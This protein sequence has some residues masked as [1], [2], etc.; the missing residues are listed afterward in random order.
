MAEVDLHLHTTFSDGNLSPTKLVRLC[1]SRGLKAIAITDHDS[2]EGLPEALAVAEELPGVT[3]IPGVELSADVSGAE[4][5]L[6]GYFVDHKDPPLQ[7]TLLRLR[8][9]RQERAREMVRKLNGMGVNISWERV[10][11]ISGGG[12]IG[13]PHIAQAMVEAHYVQY[14]RDAFTE[15]LGRNGSAY[16]EREKLSPESAAEMVVHFGALPVMAHPTYFM[17][18]TDADPVARLKRTL[19]ELKEAGLVGMEVHYGDYSTKQVEL[20][21]AVASELGLIPCGGSD[22][23]ASGNPDEPEPGSVGPPMETLSA[24]ES[25]RQSRPTAVG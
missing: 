9:S 22:Y 1:A 19:S 24:L 3:V 18:G 5:H 16:V 10:Q 4:V 7:S 25:L 12:A 20:L 13:R 17:A 23:H 21:A 14:P 8:D 15:Y 6:L 11:E 2:T